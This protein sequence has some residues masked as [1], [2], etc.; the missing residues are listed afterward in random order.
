MLIIQNNELLLHIL[1]PVVDR[2]H[3]GS[4]YCTGGY[5]WQITDLKKGTYYQGRSFPIRF[6]PDLMVR[7]R[8]KFLRPLW[9]RIVHKSTKRFW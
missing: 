1:D 3:L 9:V 7:G 5:V 4:R 2:D 8:R 6:P